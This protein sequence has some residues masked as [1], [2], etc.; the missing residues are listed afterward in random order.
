MYQ[1]AVSDRPGVT[2]LV[3]EERLAVLPDRLVAVHSRTVIAQWLRHERHGLAAAHAVFL[4]M[5]FELHHV[6][7]RVQQRVELVVD[8]GLAT[9]TWAWWAR[10]KFESGVDEVE[11]HLVAQ[12]RVVIERRNGKYP[13]LYLVL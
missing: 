13:P 12:V 1:R 11:R 7:G 2:H 3:V 10:L 6:V 8:F 5:Y 4:T 9:G